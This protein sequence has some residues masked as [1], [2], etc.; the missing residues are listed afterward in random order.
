MKRSED[1]AVTS[2]V[3]TASGTEIT[4]ATWIVREFAHH[5]ASITRKQDHCIE[6]AYQGPPL[7][8]PQGLFTHLADPP[9]SQ[10]VLDAIRHMKTGKANGCDGIEIDL[11]EAGGPEMTKALVE[12]ATL[13]WDH[14]EVPTDWSWE[15]CCRSLKGKVHAMTSTAIGA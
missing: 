14:K 13:V 3:K 6:E 1:T 12:L 5:F 2:R 10:E 8:F 11:F 15:G 7:L 9:T 4:T